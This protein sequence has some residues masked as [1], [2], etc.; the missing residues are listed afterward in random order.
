[1]PPEPLDDSRR[2]ERHKGFTADKEHG[3]DSQAKTAF[4]KEKDIR[5]AY[6]DWGWATSAMD[7]EGRHSQG[8][9]PIP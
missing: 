3:V 4:V 5:L 8:A 9:T 7:E 6:D 1:M 2:H